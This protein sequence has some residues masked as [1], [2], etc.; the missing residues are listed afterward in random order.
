MREL[1]LERL[2]DGGREQMDMLL[3]Q[4]PSGAECTEHRACLADPDALEIAEA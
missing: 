1:F 2:G 4:L 3:S